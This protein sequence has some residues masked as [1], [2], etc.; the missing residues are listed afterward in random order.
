MS[1]LKKVAT[2]NAF[3]TVG[4]Y[5]QAIAVGPQLYVSGQMPGDKNGNLVE[6]SIAEKTRA[7]CANIDAILKEAGTEVGR[8]VKVVV[9]LDD[10]ANFAEMNGEYEKYFTHKP[11]RSCVAVKQLPK[12]VP[13][14]IECIAYLG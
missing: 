11:A 13:V 10:M 3:P 5:S 2:A 7:C 6:G 14:E 9:F 12:G 4:P 1:E 8:V